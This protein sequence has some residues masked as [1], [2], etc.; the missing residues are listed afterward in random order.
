MKQIKT[1]I[2]PVAGMGTRLLPLTKAV[3]KELMPVYDRPVLQ[4]AIDEALDA[5]AERLV[6]ITSPTKP[7][8]REFLESDPALQQELLKKGK[9]DLADVLNETDV[10]QRAEVVVIDQENPKG[11]G[12]AISLAAPY[13]E[14]DA[15]GVI[16][17]DDCIIGTACLPEMVSAYQGGH[18]IA[19]QQV[20]PEDLSKYGIFDPIAAS[21]G[22]LTQCHRFV[23]K[24]RAD[25]ATSTLAAVG[26]YVLASSVMDKL[27]D[28]TPG[29]GGEVQ[30]TDAIVRDLPENR[31][32][33]FEF[34]GKRYDCGTQDGLLQAGQARRDVLA[35]PTTPVITAATV[36]ANRA[37]A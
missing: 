26:R 9:H 32:W 15:F 17:P 33:A 31:L 14:D 12:H 3:P 2:L 7:A 22:K 18:M 19:A 25:Q 16:L 8:I 20:A 10:A 23:E 1:V 5:G 35:Q 30:L 11:L 4:L 6:F 13:V 29:A 37:V 36:P 28:Q 34:S 27:S 24:P 21:A